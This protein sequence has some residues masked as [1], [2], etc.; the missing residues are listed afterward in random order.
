MK[1]RRKKKA[2]TS[3]REIK[4]GA[5]VEVKK[6]PT[7][8]QSDR[9]ALRK[10]FK[11]KDNKKKDKRYITWLGKTEEKQLTL[12][13][14]KRLILDIQ[15]KKKWH[16]AQSRSVKKD[17]PNGSYNYSGNNYKQDIYLID[18]EGKQKHYFVLAKSKEKAESKQQGKKCRAAV[19]EALKASGVNLNLEEIY[20]QTKE[21]FKRCIPKSFFYQNWRVL[22]KVLHHVSAIDASSQYPS[23]SIGKLPTTL[24]AK[25]FKGTVKPTEDYPFAFY[26]KSGHMAIHK[27]FDTHAWLR[28]DFS[29][30]LFRTV[31][32]TKTDKFL[33]DIALKKEDDITILMKAADDD[34]ALGKVMRYF[35]DKKSS[36]PKGS[37]E[38]DEWKLILNSIIGCFHYH[39][40]YNRTPWRFAH[41]AAVMIA[42]GNAKILRKCDEIGPWN[43][44]HIAVDGIIYSGVKDFS[45]AERGLGKFDIDPAL[46]C[47][48]RM[49]QS[50]CYAFFKDG[51]C[52][53]YKHGAFNKNKDGSE[54]TTPT[55]WEDMDRWVRTGE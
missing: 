55:K 21:D 11:K 13:E 28:S 26:V 31:D 16:L 12:E 44:L 53:K 7:I 8:A 2:A 3:P 48:F 41:L 37:Q 15:S 36:C 40:F 9:R 14:F 30:S 1:E 50:N 4:P 18:E 33:Q 46:D 25:A 39:D 49:T 20:G 17:W 52:V 42:R 32:K 22:G 24:G 34:G 35:Y 10:F 23:G 19:K 6:K 51:Q 43:I 29:A 5:F 47:D 54:I 45:D 38:R 27:E